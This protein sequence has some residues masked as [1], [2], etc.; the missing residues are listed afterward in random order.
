MLL[1]EQNKK[2]GIG[3]TWLLRKCQDITRQERPELAIASLDFFNV[4]DRNGVVV[5]E[6]IVEA[7]RAAFQ[8]WVPGSF[9]EAIA[10]YRN[11]KSP[12]MLKQL[13]LVVPS[14]KPLR[15]ICNI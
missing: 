13:K 8:D 6:R 2:G 3:K 9:L 14:S 11:V 15:L 10:E 7:L 12:R 5:A 1:K 4:G